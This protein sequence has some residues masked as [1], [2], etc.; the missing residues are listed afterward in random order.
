VHFKVYIPHPALQEFVTSILTINASFPEVEN[1][2]IIPY[3]PTPLQSIIFHGNFP[4][5][6]Q[7]E[8][9]FHFTL[10]PSTVIVGPQCTRANL[11]IGQRLNVVRVDFQPCGLYRL[12]GIPMKYFYDD[13]FDANDVM[14]SEV[15]T[16]NEKL[17]A[18]SNEE[19]QKV[20]VENFLLRKRKNLQKSL[21]FDSA[22]HEL[23]KKNGNITLD[24]IASLSCLG[25]RQFERICG[26]RI[27]IP[28]KVFAR[29]IRFSKAYRLKESF[30]AISWTSIAHEA[31]YFDQMHLIRDFK[32]FAG[33][34]PHMMDK[35]ILSAPI[36]MQADL[37][38]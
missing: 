33:V 10:K 2:I 24:K 31:G 11:L 18:T 26:E 21:P 14:G 32:E 16:V 15:Q 6:L 5:K 25:L 34:T 22:I 17:I 7:K 4:I 27:G 23:M 19:K 13:V 1:D 20:I 9:D 35:P 29:I 8:R 37:I 28:P 36:Q 38:I 30:P 12:L 3:P